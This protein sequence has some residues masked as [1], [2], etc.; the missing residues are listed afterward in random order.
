MVTRDLQAVGRG[1]VEHALAIV[2]GHRA[3]HVE[4]ALPFRIAGEQPR[5]VGGVAEH[6]QRLVA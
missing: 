2:H 4:D 1:A 3:V 5:M 6:E